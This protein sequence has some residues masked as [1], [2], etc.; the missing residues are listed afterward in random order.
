M[1]GTDNHYFNAREFARQ[2]AK[3]KV[4]TCIQSGGTAAVILPPVSTEAERQQLADSFKRT[5]RLSVNGGLG[6][7]S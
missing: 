4:L 3:P 5:Q 7:R 2:A 6:Q 1:S